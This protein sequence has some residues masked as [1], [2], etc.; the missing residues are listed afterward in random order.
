MVAN[1]LPSRAGLT[2]F[3]GV[4]AAFV[5]VAHADVS[6]PRPE[7]GTVATADPCAGALSQP[8][9]WRWS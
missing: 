4:L 5:D 9:C 2:S 6:I 3:V 7:D 1:A 8:R